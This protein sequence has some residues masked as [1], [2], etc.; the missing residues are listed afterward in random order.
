MAVEGRNRSGTERRRCV[1]QPAGMEGRIMAYFAAVQ[2]SEAV[3]IVREGCQWHA[4]T[5]PAGTSG[6][7]YCGRER[8]LTEGQT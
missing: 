5:L 8:R 7:G 6:P 4:E 3:R 2:R 1:D